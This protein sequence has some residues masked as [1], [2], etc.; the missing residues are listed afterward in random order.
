MEELSIA[1]QDSRWWLM[2]RVAARGGTYGALTPL[3]GPL[4]AGG[5]TFSYL[6]SAGVATANQ[7]LVWSIGITLLGESVSQAQSSA[8]GLAFVRDSLITRVALRNNARF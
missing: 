3:V 2:Q 7:L 1:Q 5:L 8:G 6:D 4:A